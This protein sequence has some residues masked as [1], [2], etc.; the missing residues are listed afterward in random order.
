[1][2]WEAAKAILIG[3]PWDHGDLYATFETVMGGV[4][5]PRKNP[6]FAIVAGLQREPDWGVREIMVLDEFESWNLRDLLKQCAAFGCQYNT[7]AEDSFRWIGDYRDQAARAIVHELNAEQEG[8]GPSRTLSRGYLSICHTPILDVQQAP[9]HLILSMVGEYIKKE[10]R[11]LVLKESKVKQHLSTVNALGPE[12]IADL[13]FGAFPAIEALSFV[14]KALRDYA[15]ADH[16]GDG[17]PPEVD[18][19]EDI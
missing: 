4:A 14:V 12:V 17:Q 7:Q 5:F 8:R 13:T 2:N 3:H 11:Q 16:E 1:M 18:P 19:L 6:G 15:E 9:Y 10:R